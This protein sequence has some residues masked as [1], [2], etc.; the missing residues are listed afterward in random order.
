MTAYDAI[1]SDLESKH[2]KIDN[3]KFIVKDLTR[4][5]IDVAIDDFVAAASSYLNGGLK[6]VTEFADK[7]FAATRFER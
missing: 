1:I 5:E 3:I 7:G 2:G 4:P 6:P